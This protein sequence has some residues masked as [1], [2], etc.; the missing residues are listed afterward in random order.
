[1]KVTE[2]RCVDCSDFCY[3]E[4]CPNRS[5]EVVYCDIC[6]SEAS[7]EIDDED[8]C[9]SCAKETL[10][11]WFNELSI[12]DKCDIFNAGLRIYE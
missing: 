3:G 8:Y 7:Y 9:E 4:T 12:E 10:Y 1:M 2:T 11:M 5:V 6:G